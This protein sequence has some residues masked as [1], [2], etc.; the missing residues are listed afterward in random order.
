MTPAILAV[1][2]ILSVAIILMV[3]EVLRADVVALLIALTL[4]L[5]GLITVQEAFSGLSRSAVVTILAIFI[6]TQG[7]Y[8]TGVTRRVGLVLTRL[9]GERPRRL[10][11]F[12]MLAGAGLSL[13]MN[14]IAAAALLLPAMMDVARRI[15]VSPSKLLLP[16]AFGVILGGMATLLTTSNIVV[17]TALKDEGLAPYGLLDFAPVG[18]PLVAVGTA[19]M[20][21]VG[22]RL[23]PAVSPAEQLGQANQL[24]QELTEMYALEERLS[25]VRVAS[26][27]PLVGQPIADSQI[28]EKLG[29][30]ILAIWHNHQPASIA[31]SP[32]EIIRAGDILLIAGRAE[33]VQQLTDLGGEILENLDWHSDLAT[34]RVALLEVLIAPRSRAAGH[35]LK[36]LHFRAKYDLSVVAIWRGGRSYRTDVGDI[37]LQFGDALLVHG[38]RERIAVLRAD[39]DFLV[40][41][42]LDEPPRTQKGWLTVTIMALALIVTA[43]N[44]LPI[45]EAMM[46]GALGMVIAGCLTMDEAYRA[47]EW[48]AIFL[49]AGM[50]PAG[51]A[52]SR[53][54]AADWLGHLLVTT[55]AGWGPLALA[56]GLFLLATLL[57]QVMSG[58]VAAVVLAPI[59]IAAARGLGTEPRAMAMAT[60][61]GCSMAFLTPTGHPVNVFVMGP[62]GYRFRDFVRVGLPLTVLLFV[63]LLLVLPVFWPLQ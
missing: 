2:A 55:L 60:A 20:L 53:S 44:L 19:Y 52:L 37:P 43:T 21:L 17:S 51:I 26:T 24:R 27:S 48:R 31:P 25:E 5:T 59:A 18:L 35:T 47:I 33:R 36:E 28:G 13:F 49:I 4:A 10:L 54:G 63:T 15:R 50:L 61:L 16:L 29:L 22:Y 45:A 42:E 11:L 40:L 62:G 23:L 57:T 6:L 32:G 3:T 56:G 39:P 34:A 41:A 1:L 8:R 30:S 58:Q 46:L 14:N 38:P 12:T 7:L 9:A